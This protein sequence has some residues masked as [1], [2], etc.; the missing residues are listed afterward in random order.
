MRHSTG[1]G[2]QGSVR[3]RL[4]RYRH[5]KISS[6]RTDSAAITGVSSEFSIDAS[7]ELGEMEPPPPPVTVDINHVTAVGASITTTAEQSFD[8]EASS[9]QGRLFRNAFRRTLDSGYGDAQ[10]CDLSPVAEPKKLMA[11]DSRRSANPLHSMVSQSSKESNNSTSSGQSVRKACRLRRQKA[12]DD[13][14]GSAQRQR[15]RSASQPAPD[16]ERNG[17]STLSSSSDCEENDEEEVVEEFHK[18]PVMIRIRSGGRR[19]PVATGRGEPVQQIKKKTSKLCRKT[20]M[21]I[22]SSSSSD[23]D[24]DEVH[25]DSDENTMKR[26]AKTT[27]QRRRLQLKL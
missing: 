8:D 21:T 20:S 23:I 14:V 2:Q 1:S 18:D 3:L 16:K 7:L 10:S 4:K 25:S 9:A 11:N 6:S 24:G 15:L 26:W 22:S 17:K 27:S 5:R 12:F 19:P 13:R